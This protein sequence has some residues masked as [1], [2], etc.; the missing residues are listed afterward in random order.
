MSLG[1]F[2]W[3]LRTHQDFEILKQP[4]KT[5]LSVNLTVFGAPNHGHFIS[6]CSLTKFHYPG[7]QP[8]QGFASFLDRREQQLYLPTMSVRNTEGSGDMSMDEEVLNPGR[9]HPRKEKYL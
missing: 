4:Y 2:P 7:L 9:S 8:L 3:D 6:V 5:L 1:P